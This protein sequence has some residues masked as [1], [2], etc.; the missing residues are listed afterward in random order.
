MD[1]QH[2]MFVCMY[3]QTYVQRV[4]N[5]HDSINGRNSLKAKSEL[6]IEISVKLQTQV[7]L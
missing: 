3:M 5:M 2:S 7:T 6:K 4:V 1:T